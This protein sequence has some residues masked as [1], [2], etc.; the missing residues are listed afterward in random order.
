M[1]EFFLLF[2]FKFIN[3]NLTATTTAPNTT[4]V[5]TSPPLR[6]RKPHVPQQQ[7]IL[8]NTG[9]NGARDATSR[10]SGMYFLSSLVLLKQLHY[11]C[12]NCDD[13]S[14]NTK[15]TPNTRLET[16]RLEPQVC[17]FY[18]FSSLLMIFYN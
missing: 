14:A 15:P 16:L 18:S 5:A 3:Y 13:N 2:K 9:T 4:S 17:F 11:M 6:V 12:R 8:S 1:G 7:Q 10:G